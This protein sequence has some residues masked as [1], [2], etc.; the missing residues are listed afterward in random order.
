[1]LTFGIGGG[2]VSFW[3]IFF[4]KNRSSQ[5]LEFSAST[6]QDVGAVNGDIPA[7]KSQSTT[8]T[9]SGNLFAVPLAMNP[10]KN[11]SF[12][13]RQLKNAEKSTW[14]DPPV[15]VGPRSLPEGFIFFLSLSSFS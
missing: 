3:P 12:S 10:R 4:F 15:V 8:K 5:Q 13:F 1:M 9:K 11:I 6:S 14:S 2:L 7:A